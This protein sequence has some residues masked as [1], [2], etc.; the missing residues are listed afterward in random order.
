MKGSHGP[1]V[2]EATGA[3]PEGYFA[4]WL[5]YQDASPSMMALL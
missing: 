1:H 4:G 5:A 2:A 3:L